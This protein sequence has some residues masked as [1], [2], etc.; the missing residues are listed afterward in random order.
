M[1]KAS[2]FGQRWMKGVSREFALKILGSGR[3]PGRALSS[4]AF[5]RPITIGR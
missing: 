5:E 4:C 2:D 3:Y 1:L